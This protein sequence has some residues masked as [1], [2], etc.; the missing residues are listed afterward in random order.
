MLNNESIEE[1]TILAGE[2][3]PFSM[4]STKFRLLMCPHFESRRRSD[5]MVAKALFRC[6]ASGELT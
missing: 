6:A 4:H 2:T 5:A 3:D 1:V